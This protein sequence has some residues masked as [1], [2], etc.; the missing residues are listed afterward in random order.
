MICWKKLKEY[1]RYFYIDLWRL[2]LKTCCVITLIEFCFCP[3]NQKAIIELPGFLRLFYETIIKTI[4]I[5]D[6][7]EEALKMI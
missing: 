5:N 2:G 1:C 6:Y 4:I 7:S 3:T